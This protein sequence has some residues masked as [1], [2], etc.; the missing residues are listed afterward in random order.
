MVDMMVYGEQ[1]IVL[2]L[3]EKKKIRSLQ[4]KSCQKVD[5]NTLEFNRK[6]TQTGINRP[7]N[8]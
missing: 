8:N 2:F 7:I 3:R 1:K 4:K 5:F 6:M